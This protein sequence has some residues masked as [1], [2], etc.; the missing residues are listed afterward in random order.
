MEA[1]LCGIYTPSFKSKA[2][3]MKYSLETTAKKTKFGTFVGF[4]LEKAKKLFDFVT[5]NVSLPD[6]EPQLGGDFF[7]A[8]ADYLADKGKAPT[9]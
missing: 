3:L 6:V 1:S 7:K 4:N 8:M 5:E 2:D 9:C